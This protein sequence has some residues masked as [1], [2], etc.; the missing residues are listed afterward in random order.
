MAF[1]FIIQGSNIVVIIRN[2]PHTVSKTHISYEK[3]KE[4]I[5]ASDWATVEDLIEPK[6]TIL[7][8]G[9]GNVAIQGEKLF[10]KDQELN[11][12]LAMKMIQMFQEGFPIEPMVNFMENLMQNPSRRAVNEL[13]KFLEK[14]N[15]PITPDGCF[16]AYKKVR[17]DFRDV[18]SGTVL[19]KPAYML[20]ADERSAVETAK[21]GKVNEVKIEIVADTEGG[22]S[23]VISMER[24]MVDDNA[25]N[26]CSSG[27]HF[28]SKDYLNNFGGEKIVILKINPRDVVSVPADY[29][30]TKGRTCR[31]EVIGELGVAPEEAFTASVQAGI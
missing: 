12:G 26:T 31:Y 4:A 22:W 2:K 6:K 8:Y 11:N 13:Y 20:T 19:N 15:M 14:G 16:L 23:T 29:N 24:N 9:A 28:C 10:W 5:K 3:I 17:D 30:D 25:N 27:L 7:N 21:A 1:P 18:H